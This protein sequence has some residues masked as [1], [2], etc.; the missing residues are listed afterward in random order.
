MAGVVGNDSCLPRWT[1][2][3][4]C[5]TAA[6]QHAAE[7]R[8]QPGR[9]GGWGRGGG[10]WK[11]EEAEEVVVWGG[12]ERVAYAGGVDG[13]LMVAGCVYACLGG[14]TVDSLLS[15]HP[16]IMLVKK[17]ITRETLDAIQNNLWLRLNR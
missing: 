10:C 8:W 11:G 12:Q 5:S 9:S 14:G 4:H 6:V 3:C 13:E 7:S 1:L 2:I 16:N 17:K 15:Q